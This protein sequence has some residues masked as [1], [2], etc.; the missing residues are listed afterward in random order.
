MD[1]VIWTV[2]VTQSD[3]RITGATA[4]AG[5]RDLEHSGPELPHLALLPADIAQHEVFRGGIHFQ[6]LHI[7]GQGLQPTFSANLGS[8][9]PNP[10]KQLECSSL[11][12]RTD[13]HPQKK[14]TLELFQ[15]AE[16]ASTGRGQLSVR[17][18]IIAS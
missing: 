2:Q 8:G 1:A 9:V 12:A 4:R 16:Q 18:A 5:T 14:H 10:P 17:S 15:W 6:I 13:C 3:A 7:Q 11:A